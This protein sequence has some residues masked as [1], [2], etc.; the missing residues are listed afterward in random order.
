MV[1]LTGLGSPATYGSARSNQDKPP[2]Q[3]C[4]RSGL[5]LQLGP[6]A[7]ALF[8]E[9]LEPQL[10]TEQ[11]GENHIGLPVYVEWPASSGELG[12]GLVL[13]VGDLFLE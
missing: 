1:A 7:P 8:I 6:Q 12:Q 9:P 10:G 3:A 13:E 4:R 5:G 11:V 2:A